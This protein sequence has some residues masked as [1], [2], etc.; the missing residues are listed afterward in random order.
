MALP[1]SRHFDFQLVEF[2]TDFTFP[3]A[4]RLNRTLRLRPAREDG[5]ECLHGFTHLTLELF[6]ACR[7]FRAAC[8]GVLPLPFEGFAYACGFREVSFDHL[9]LALERAESDRRG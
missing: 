8:L 9:Q 6:D 3:C 4:Q 2:G 5:L 7:G 1:F